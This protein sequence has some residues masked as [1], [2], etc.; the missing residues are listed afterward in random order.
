MFHSCICED[1]SFD[2]QRLIQTQQ[3]IIVDC[4]CDLWHDAGDELFDGFFRYFFPAG[5]IDR[6]KEQAKK[7]IRDN[8]I[9]VCQF[10]L[11]GES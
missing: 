11:G 4:Y 8:R 2:L 9:G 3:E 7:I 1:Y 5:F 6:D 10:H